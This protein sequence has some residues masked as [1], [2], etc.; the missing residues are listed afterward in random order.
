MQSVEY[1]PIG[2]NFAQ[3]AK[4]ENVSEAENKAAEEAVALQVVKARA[5]RQAT[6]EVLGEMQP[7][8]IKR[9][10]AKLTALGLA[11]EDIEGGG[12]VPK[13]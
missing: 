12:D 9:A 11:T 6:F 5:V 1:P 13:V 4:G 3:F 2:P 7:E 8:I 10:K